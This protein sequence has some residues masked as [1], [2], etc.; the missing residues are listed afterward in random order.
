M[1]PVF[2]RRHQILDLFEKSLAK[3]FSV[4]CDLLHGRVRGRKTFPENRMA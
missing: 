3:N 1:R 2:L 4:V